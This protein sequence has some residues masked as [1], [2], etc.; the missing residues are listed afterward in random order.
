MEWDCDIFILKGVQRKKLANL[1]VIL[2]NIVDR[3]EGQ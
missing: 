2:Y 1:S 3:K